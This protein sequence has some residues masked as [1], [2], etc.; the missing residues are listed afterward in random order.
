MILVFVPHP[1]SKGTESDSKT[2]AFLPLLEAGGRF[3]NRSGVHSYG[4]H[5]RH[6][7]LSEIYVGDV[8][9]PTL[10]SLD[11]ICSLI[12]PSLP[13]RRFSPPCLPLPR[14]RTLLG[15]PLGMNFR[16]RVS[17]K[18]GLPTSVFL[19]PPVRKDGEYVLMFV[20]RA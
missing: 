8:H 9:N 10:T 11:R 14:Q 5:E 6:Q 4:R 1:S 13:L 17:T 2:G 7:D 16:S 15:L 20:S 18:E 19:L 3:M 12:S